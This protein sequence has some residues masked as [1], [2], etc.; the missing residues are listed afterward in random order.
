MTDTLKCKKKQTL[1]DILL[2]K[3]QINHNPIKLI[4]KEGEKVLIINAVYGLGNRL[5]A[6]A[7]AYSICKK[8]NMKL[9]INW[10][11]DNHCNCNINDLIVNI[12]QYAIIYS[13][14]IDTNSLADFRYYN[15]LETEDEGKKDEYIDDSIYKLYVK[16]NCILNNKNSF[17]YFNDFLQ[18][19]EW[20]ENINKLINNFPKIHNY[21]GL[22]IRMG[23]GKQ[24]QHTSADKDNNWTKG[25]TELMFKYREISHIDNFINQI[26]NIL[27]KNPQQKFFIATDMKS[28]YEKLINIYGK[29]RI[30]FLQR[31]SFDRSK[32]ENFYGVADI[33]LL[34][35]CQHFYGSY[36]SSFSELVTYFQ[37]R[38]VK[39]NTFSNDFRLQ[40]LSKEIN[41]LNNNLKEGNSIVSVSMNRSENIIKVLPSWLKI[42]NCH[43][44][45]ILD[46]GSE[47]PLLNT[48]KYHNFN[49]SRIKIYR[50]EN[51]YKWHLSKAY[52]LAI[53]LSS[54]KN[55]Y[56]L[57]SDDICSVN[58]IDHHP[59]NDVSNIYYHG[60]WQDAKNDNEL[61]IA[62]KMFF[63]YD[64]F[65]NSNGYNENITT[66]GWDDCDFDLRLKQIG[67]QKHINI[68]D[69][70]FIKHNDDDRQEKNEP[71]TVQQYIHINELLCKKNVLNWNIKS[72]HSK[73]IQIK[74]T[75][76][77]LKLEDS[78]HLTYDFINKN[79]L[80]EV[81]SFV[82]KNW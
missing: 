52:N 77:T 1:K 57:D 61:Q 33:I 7:S 39:N 41:F 8:K 60:R 53:K 31:N 67:T 70:V 18:S 81:V 71:N 26:N 58:L 34:S 80:D 2:P 11:P 79:K 19:L 42:N 43:E 28:N 40:T 75:E 66:Y 5:R 9:I 47:N 38:D 73:F 78:Y 65:V 10:I 13:N 17:I 35:R 55:I 76:N 63:T 50:V 54:Y 32:E 30:T 69:F 37:T 45:I 14:P 20:N 21:I 49:D 59:L 64:M 48:L 15:Y 4:F 6:I 24:F 82:K 22:H 3:C 16:S 74:I 68:N 29:N 51:V 46:Y 27:H 25:E 56:K 72:L 62:G 23:G 12:D 36:W 44:I